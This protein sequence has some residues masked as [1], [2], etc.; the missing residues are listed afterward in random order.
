MIDRFGKPIQV[1]WSFAE[2]DMLTALIK[3]GCKTQHIIDFSQLTGRSI[4]AILVHVKK[5]QTEERARLRRKEKMASLKDLALQ[6][7]TER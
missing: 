2:E 3:M 5:R 4:L 7:T 1:A 6:R